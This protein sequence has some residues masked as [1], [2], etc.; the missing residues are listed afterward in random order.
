MPDALASRRRQIIAAGPLAASFAVSASRGA[1]ASKMVH[2][3]RGRASAYAGRVRVTLAIGI[4]VLGCSRADSGNRSVRTNS[5]PGRAEPMAQPDASPAGD[6]DAGTPAPSSECPEPLVGA[7]QSS[8]AV[9]ARSPAGD[10]CRY[11]PLGAAPSDWPFFLTEEACQNDCRCPSVDGEIQFRTSLECICSIEDCPSSI[12][13][14]EQSLC[15]NTSGPPVAAVQ[16]VVGC[17]MVMV[18]DRNGFSGSGWVFE[19]PL[20]SA[21][22]PRLVG[23]SRFSDASTKGCDPNAWGAGRDFSECEEEVVTCQLCGE[24]PG[25]E[26]PPCE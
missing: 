25:L 8:Q 12:E 2:R 3:A 24:S 11:A 10:C 22:A 1:R 18:V 4:L 7:F 20:E 21:G 23:S 15:S 13:E 5:E 17:G 26:F 19:Q 6:D 9:W 14:A 16:R